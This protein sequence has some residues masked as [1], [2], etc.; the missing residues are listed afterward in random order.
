ME[1]FL[2]RYR[3]PSILVIVVFAQVLVLAMQVKR[4]TE[5]GS[6][7]LVRLWVVNSIT[8]VEKTLVNSGHW[9][10]GLWGNYL[11]LRG[12][13]QEN[14]EL[15]Q[16]IERM[17]VEQVRL[18]E[19]A[20][21]ARRL[22]ALLAFKEQFI[23]QTLPAQVIGTS[24][25]DQSRTIYIDKGSSDGVKPDMAVIT[26]DGIV[27]KVLRVFH[28]S[29]QVLEI[30]DQSSGV[31]AI[32]E[33]S[34]LQGILQGTAS[35]E[36]LMRYVMSDERVQRGER[37]LTSG[38]DR[39]FPKGLPIGNVVNSATGSDLF[40]NIRVKPTA[41]LSKIE[42]VLVVT[43]LVEK[44]PDVT[45]PVGVRKAADIL[46]ERLPSV[47]PKPPQAPAAGVQSPSGKPGET[48]PPTT[49]AATATPGAK[50]AGSAAVTAKP[51]TGTS[52]ASGTPAKPAGTPAS[53]AK[54]PS[55][56]P[57]NGNHVKAPAAKPKVEAG[58]PAEP[59][60]EAPVE[61]AP[62]YPKPQPPGEVPQ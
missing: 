48:K 24:G 44:E 49:T 40:L 56:K 46:A 54:P 38:G 18:R 15:R 2:T 17:R 5:G 55:A 16:E 47:S 41:N 51:T 31:G 4:P 8:P 12:V 28:S 57:A 23:S 26:P 58:A 32:L 30:N 62:E 60:P 13:R 27:G 10:R 20:G 53:A 59:K 61:P 14:R 36:V 25:S 11:Y 33:N 35:G 7:R 3:N 22:Q 39:I 52:G 45:Q 42:E 34:R 6:T 37:V 50:P 43:K 19:D 21:Q 9:V 1:N 29:A